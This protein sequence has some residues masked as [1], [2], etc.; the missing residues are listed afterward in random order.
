[1]WING[2]RFSMKQVIQQG[3]RANKLIL[4]PIWRRR[5]SGWRQITFTFRVLQYEWAAAQTLSAWHRY[6]L[7]V[8]DSED[9]RIWLNVIKVISQLIS[10]WKW[11]LLSYVN[12][13]QTLTLVSVQRWPRQF[14]FMWYWFKKW[15][16]LNCS[17]ARRSQI[18]AGL[19]LIL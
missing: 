18:P 1:M 11:S 2:V 6:F 8:S 5:W 12:R 17:K 9:Q 3:Y 14:T 15:E 7:I 19:K 13:W 16:N 10:T 4:S